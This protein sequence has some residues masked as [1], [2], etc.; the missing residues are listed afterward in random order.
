MKN[1]F[2]YTLNKLVGKTIRLSKDYVKEHYLELPRNVKVLSWGIDSDDIEF[3]VLKT[4][5]GDIYQMWH[6]E[7]WPFR[8]LD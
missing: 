7:T 5:H 6:E 4:N 3:F 8:I 2:Y 1:P